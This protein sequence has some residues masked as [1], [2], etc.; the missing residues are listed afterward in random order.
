MFRHLP[1]AFYIMET[2]TPTVHAMHLDVQPAR[3]V[4]DGTKTIELRLYDAKR[5][6]IRVGDIIVFHSDIGS[7]TAQ[8]RALHVFDTFDRLYGQLDLTKCGYTA[9]QLAAASPDDMLAYYDIQQQRKWGVVGIEIQ[10]L[11]VTAN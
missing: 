8:V 6:R 10:L 9:E 4:A 3:A 7:I 1:T 2:N 5:R 11:Q